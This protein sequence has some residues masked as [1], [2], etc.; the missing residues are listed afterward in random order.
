MLLGSMALSAT[1]VDFENK[2]AHLC[3]AILMVRLA[4]SIHTVDILNKSISA[5]QCGVYALILGAILYFTL[6]IEQ[7]MPV[8]FHRVPKKSTSHEMRWKLP[9]AT[10]SLAL[11]LSVVV[12]QVVDMTF[13]S[14]RSAYLGDASR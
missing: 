4:G 11:C 1:T 2:L 3:C 14:G 13:G 8:S 5:I 6:K 7:H 12:F 9:V 10:I